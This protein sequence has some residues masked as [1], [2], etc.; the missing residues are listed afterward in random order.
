VLE[1]Y[2]YWKT[3][4]RAKLLKDFV[5]PPSTEL[6]KAVLIYRDS[7]AYHDCKK[8]KY[9]LELMEKLGVDCIVLNEKSTRVI[10]AYLISEEG[11]L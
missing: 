5:L 3:V 1:V 9:V 4:D 8:G 2:T 7:Q 6:H 11:Y 10:G